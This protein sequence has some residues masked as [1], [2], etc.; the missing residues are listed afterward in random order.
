M[1]PVWGEGVSVD[2]RAADVHVQNIRRRIEPA[3][4]TPRY[5]LTV[6]GI[7]YKFAEFNGNGQTPT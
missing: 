1:E 7:G 6:R 2:S 3:P 4:S 5:V